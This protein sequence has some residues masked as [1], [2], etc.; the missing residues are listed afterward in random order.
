MRALNIAFITD[1][2]QFG[3]QLSVRA[4]QTDTHSAV[5]STYEAEFPGD[6]SRG[7]YLNR[8]KKNSLDESVHFTWRSVPPSRCHHLILYQSHYYFH[9]LVC[10]LHPLHPSHSR[11]SV[12]MEWILFLKYLLTELLFILGETCLFLVS[13]CLKGLC[14]SEVVIVSRE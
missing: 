4:N 14:L 12:D 2:D 3:T 13:A 6:K 9:L 1:E 5:S 11:S 7:F 10:L 8:D